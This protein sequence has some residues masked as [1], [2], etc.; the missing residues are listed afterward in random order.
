MFELPNSRNDCGLVSIT[1]S[2]LSGFFCI[3]RG[4]SFKETYEI[5]Y[6]VLLEIVFNSSMK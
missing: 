2:A 6:P 3:Y 4:T 5:L 1:K